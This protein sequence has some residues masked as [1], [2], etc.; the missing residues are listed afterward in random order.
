MDKKICIW[1]KMSKIKLFLFFLRKKWFYR[2]LK[3]IRKYY[4]SCIH[5]SVDCT[6][7]CNFDFSVQQL[8]EMYRENI[9][10][11]NTSAINNSQFTNRYWINQ[12]YSKTC[13]K[14]LILIYLPR[15][16]QVIV[17]QKCTGKDYESLGKPV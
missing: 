4:K 15:I 6:H 10:N 5:L 11:Y 3:Y 7:C 9:F 14:T 8:M 13:L 16:C 2:C 12:R 1:L 17:P